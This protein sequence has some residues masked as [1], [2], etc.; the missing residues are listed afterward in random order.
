M[1]KSYLVIIHLFFTVLLSAQ[2]MYVEGGKALTSFDYKNS[3]GE[4]LNNLQSQMNSFMG[5]GY[6]HKIKSDRLNA[7]VGLNYAGY[8]AVGSDDFF[9]DYMEWNLNYL[10][11]VVGMDYTF[12]KLNKFSI[13]GKGNYAA[14]FLVQ[15]TQIINNNVIDLKSNSDYDKKIMHEFRIGSG[16][17]YPISDDL[18][19]YTQY[20]Y[21]KTLPI[22]E[23]SGGQSNRE[24]LK[25]ESNSVVFGL[26]INLNY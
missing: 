12:L 20:T 23:G 16:F 25:I 11:T 1:K 17:T 10:Q 22:K 3:Q 9:N 26:L 14:S 7:S 21:G 6:K 18:S 2:Q 4:K 13:Y 19:F 24:E 5:I 15:G 8:G